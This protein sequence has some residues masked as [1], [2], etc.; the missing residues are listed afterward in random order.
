[1]IYRY[2]EERIGFYIIC[3]GCEKVVYILLSHLP[4]SSLDVSRRWV[5][6]VRG[7]NCKLENGR[8]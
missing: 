1:M 5:I 7:L 3:T 6:S 4:P 8:E 2:S